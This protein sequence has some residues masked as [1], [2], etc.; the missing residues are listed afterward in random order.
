MDWFGW[1][2][3]KDRAHRLAPFGPK[4]LLHD[5]DTRVPRYLDDVDLGRLVYPDC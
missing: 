2:L 3:P 5:L 1:Q 4:T